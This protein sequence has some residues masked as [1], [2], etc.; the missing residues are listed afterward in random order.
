MMTDADNESVTDYLSGLPPAERGAV[1]D[2]L[3]TALLAI[4]L[5]TRSLWSVA[6]RPITVGQLRCYL[7]R[8]IQSLRA[9]RDSL[10]T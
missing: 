1:V 9:A 5:S 7:D 8:G 10:P 4:R 3:T 6:P 2:L